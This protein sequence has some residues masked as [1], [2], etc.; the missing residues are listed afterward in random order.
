[1]AFQKDLLRNKRNVILILVCM[2]LITFLVV[3]KLTTSQSETNPDKNVVTI[4]QVARSISM[5]NHT[6]DECKEVKDYFGGNSNQW[7]VPYMNEM[8]EDEYY[9]T[10]EIKPTDSKATSPFT[11]DSLEKLYTNMGI[12]DEELWS[13]VYN[14]KASNAIITKEWNEIYAKLI[15]VLN[16]EDVVREI[17]LAVVG[18]VSNVPTIPSWQAVTTAGTYY[19][20]G[21]SIDYYI[22]REVTALVKDNEILC[23][24]KAVSDDVTYNNAWIITIENGKMK[25]FIEGAIREFEINDKQA[26]YSSVIADIVIEN[27]KVE[28]YTIKSKSVSGKVLSSGKSGIELEEIGFFELEDNIKV[29]KTYGSMQMKSVNDVLVG[30]DIQKFILNDEG[31]ISAVAIDRDVNAKNIRVL[32]KSTGHTDMYHDSVTIESETPYEIS[33]ASDSKIVDGGTKLTLDV[34]STYL[35][36]G[37]MVISSQSVNGKIKISSIERGYGTP[38]YRGTIEIAVKDGR[39]VIVNELPIEQYLYAVVP[40]EMPYTY[41]SEALKSQA[42]C[43]RSYAYRQLLNNSLSE[44]GAHVDDSTSFQVYNNS[45][46]RITATSAVDETYGEIL[47]CGEEIVNAFFFSTSCGSSTDATVWGGKGLE[48]IKGHILTDEDIRIDLSKE[49][50]F[51]TFIRNQYNTFD[52][53]YAWY[54]WS[55]KMSLSDMTKTVNEVIGNLYNADKNKVLTL[56]NNGTYISKPLNSVGDVK[57]I[58]LGTRSTGGVLDYIIIHGTDA[59]VKVIT[60]SYIRKLFYPVS[61]EII[62]NDGSANS[63]FN[64]L[65]SA[66]IVADP[67]VNN[68]VIEGYNIIGGGYGHG[69]GL[70]Q[71]GANTMGN[72]GKTYREILTFFYSN[73]EITKMY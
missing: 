10:R 61:Y 36:S 54:R 19:F 59:T 7:Y 6:T 11:Y 5:I 70:S 30:Y 24:K 33:Y 25:A 15:K 55:L 40:S 68:G 26:I 56:E 69:V 46:E 34:S 50:N 41:N 21:L 2:A 66:Y 12:A 62:R 47:M 48:Y 53:A 72:N 20:T 39:L 4:A 31:K 71:N 67:I 42:V 16:K 44:Y 9:L 3:Y 49:T 23:V 60:E 28:E 32:I 63:S 17:N 43:A 64:M 38:A 13:Y 14:N 51:D 57:R 65:P 29:Y 8:Y 52:S 58:E 1:M 45:E 73:I 37:R 18:T 27:R 35:Q 22:D